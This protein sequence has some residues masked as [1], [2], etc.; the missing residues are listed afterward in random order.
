VG[1]AAAAPTFSVGPSK[2]VRCEVHTIPHTALLG[3]INIRMQLHFGLKVP[4]LL[5]L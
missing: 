4:W 3:W 5:P 1:E 2:R